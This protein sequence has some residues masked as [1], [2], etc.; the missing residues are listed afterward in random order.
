M[1]VTRA[2]PAA[3]TGFSILAACSQGPSPE[4]IGKSSDA[5]QQSVTVTL[6]AGIFPADV[7]IGANGTLTIADRVHVLGGAEQTVN[8]GSGQSTFGADSIVNDVTSIGSV[9]LAGRASVQGNLTTNGTITRQS[10][11]TVSGVLTTGAHVQSNGVS[12]SADIPAASAGDVSVQPDGSA[13]RPPGRYGNVTLNSR[14]KLT[15]APGRYFLDRLDLEP[16]SQLIV[17]PSSSDPDGSTIIYINSDLI[18]RAQITSSLSTQDAVL[19]V[20][21]GTNQVSIGTALSVTLVAPNASVDV[22]SPSFAGSIFSKNAT[23]EPGCV[24]QHIPFAF[25]DVLVPPT[26]TINAPSQCVA[27]L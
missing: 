17:T 8:S 2:I 1:R 10:G 7:V 3:V 22:S 26:S 27:S 18:L 19:L 24:V 20:Y 4:S 14:A 25:W 9:F 12:W 16:Q 11:A 6:P 23:I 21:T 13:S 5:L 15:I